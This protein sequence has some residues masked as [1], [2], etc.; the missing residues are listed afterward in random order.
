MVDNQHCTWNYR[1]IEFGN[2]VDGLPWREIREVHYIDGV[3]NAYSGGPIVMAYYLEDDASWENPRELLDKCFMAIHKPV[4]R[5]SDF[6]IRS[7][8]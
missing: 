5:P 6:K 3:P 2:G 7:K 4:L 1:V 8:V